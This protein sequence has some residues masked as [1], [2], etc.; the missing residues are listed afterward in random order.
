MR[1]EKTIKQ[2]RYAKQF[3]KLNDLVVNAIDDAIECLEERERVC[4]WRLSTVL[5]CVLWHAVCGMDWQ[6]ANPEATPKEN[7]M[8]YCPKCG[9]KIEVAE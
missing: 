2:L 5:D 9:R 8:V 7:E 3:H 4:G 6:F 1:T